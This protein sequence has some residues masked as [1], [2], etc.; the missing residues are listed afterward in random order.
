MFGTGVDI[1]FPKSNG[2]LYKQIR[3]NGL[4]VSEYPFGEW[5]KASNFPERNR[6]IAGLSE[7]CVVAEGAVKSGSLITAGLAAEQGRGVF[8]LPGNINQ[9]GSA[10]TNL[11]ISEGVPPI[12]SMEHVL[13]I[14]GLEGLPAESRS[15]LSEQEKALLRHVRGCGSSSKQYI[16]ET[17]SLGA[18]ESS[19]LLTCLELKGLVRLEG[20]QVFIL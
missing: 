4:L 18:Q 15:D 19:M 7:S 6:I 16:C 12:D 10:G 5:G 17:C 9:P 8:A 3:E 20:G 1:C 11:L 13:K 2:K 14:L